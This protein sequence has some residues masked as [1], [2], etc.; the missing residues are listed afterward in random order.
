M[1]SQSETAAFLAATG[2]D[3]GRIGLC[4]Q[5]PGGRFEGRPVDAAALAAGR[6]GAITADQPA[7]VWAGAGLLRSGSIP[8]GRGKASDV[9]ALPSLF[10]DLDVVPN[11]VPSIEVATTIVH[12]VSTLLVTQPCALVASGHGL[13]P[14][15]RLEDE[16]GVTCWSDDDDRARLRMTA[17]LEGFGRLVALVAAGHD[18]S[19]D[20]V[21]DLARVMRLPFPGGGNFKVEG[22]PR[23]VELLSVDPAAARVK[24][25]DL[26]A[27][28]EVHAPPAAAVA[29]PVAPAAAQ[30]APGAQAPTQAAQAP[31]I[32][33]YIAAMDRDDASILAD[34][35]TWPEGQ[36]DGYGRG[37][38]KTL[39]DL[40]RRRGAIDRAGWS[41]RD[42]AVAL[43][44]IC[45]EP[46]IE[47]AE[48]KI[49]EQWH[50]AD[51]APTPTPRDPGD[52]T[53]VFSPDYVAPSGQAAQPTAVMAARGYYID[54]VDGLRVAT[55]ARDIRAMGPLAAGR[56]DIMWSYRD[57]VWTSDRN[58]VRVR[59]AF[60]LGEDYRRSH[61]TNAEDVVRAMS[62]PI[63]CEPVS[64]VI[65]FR[66]GLYLWRA[67]LLQPHSPDVLSTVQLSVD[68]DPD[69]TC[70]E[71]DTWLS[72]VVPADMIELI[73]ELIGYLLYSGNPL[74]KAVMLMGGG[75]NGK[76]T[77]LRVVNALLGERNVTSVS[78]HDLVS[79]RFSTVCLFGKIANIAGDIDGTYL[80]TTATFKSITGQ[81]QI[82]GEHK[83]RD[84][85]DFTPW[86]VPVF[87]ANKIPPSVDTTT[88]YLSRW[89]VVPFPNDF[90]GHEDRTLDARL[91]A[92][93][94][95]AGVAAKAMPALRR[96][97]AR[98]EFALPKSGQD[99]RD[100]F[101]RRVDQ[102]RAWVDECADVDPSHP[103]VLR[104]TLYGAYKTWAARDGHKPVRAGEFYD[105]LASIPG[106]LEHRTAKV[107][108]RGFVGVKVA[109][110]AEQW[111]RQPPQ[112]DGQP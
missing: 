49:R 102:V 9:V 6:L 73:W 66:N 75:R 25:A 22:A 53:D 52:S 110:S 31:R 81:D 14:W 35:A 2:R 24:L 97:M 10:A 101:G 112:W 46:M 69:A 11:K 108:T 95:L 32:A 99:A 94:V 107:G 91:H 34:M 29:Q 50:R 67:E 7:N 83:G 90:T 61:G 28:I 111:W 63:A 37:W 80:E 68:W 30:P 96:L 55:L 27:L 87:S 48:Q 57:G 106:C 8:G 13:Q 74:H 104:T 86:A 70:P 1:T 71:F 23:P 60:L 76:G 65:N 84:R 21:S 36:R 4:R 12:E 38:E 40:A 88:G 39:S 89:L 20:K 58:V 45:P 5:I 19:V 54:K 98:G 78:L 41:G 17:A 82:S 100:E 105:R 3:H 18:A 16:E 85:F 103:F 93:D 72:Q 79:T 15:W 109:E 47:I 33:A 51:P 64:E 62:P 44:A 77:F 59:A 92:K 43:R 56:D 42:E 26:E